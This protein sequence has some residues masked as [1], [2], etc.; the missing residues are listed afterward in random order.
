MVFFYGY[1]FLKISMQGKSESFYSYGSFLQL[2]IFKYGYTGGWALF[3]YLK[4][5]FCPKSVQNTLIKHLQI[6]S[7]SATSVKILE[8]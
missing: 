5:K 7:S 3:F 4:L 8:K 2:Q 6:F 1:K